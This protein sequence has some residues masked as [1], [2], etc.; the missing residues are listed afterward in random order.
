MPSLSFRCRLLRPVLPLTRSRALRRLYSAL[1]YLLFPVVVGRLLWRSLRLPAYRRRF[2]ERLGYAAR[3]DGAAPV[4]VHAVSVGEA[5]AAVP[6]VR[7]LRGR[8]P[9]IP[10]AMTTMTP[11]GAERVRQA[12]GETVKHSYVP[13]DM[14]G[15]VSR[16]LDRVR[17]RMVI[18]VETEL[19]PNLIHFAARRGVPV[20]LVNARLSARSAARYAWAGSLVRSM[21]RDL[22]ALACQAEPD[23]QRFAALGVDPK[24]TCVTGNVKFDLKLAASLREEAAVVRREW[25]VSRPVWVA[26]STHEGEE[27]QV[28]TAAARVKETFPDCLL[29]LVPRHPERFGR[30]A[31][32]CRRRGHQVVLRSE[33]RLCRAETDVFLGDSM[34]ELPLFYAASDVAFVGGSL[35]PVGGHNVVEPAALGMPVLF[36][37]HVFNF[38]SICA[39]LREAGVGTVVGDAAALAAEVTTYLGDA[40]LRHAAGERAR[41]LADANRGAL[42]AV[43]KVLTPFLD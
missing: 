31:S 25:G 4:W 28:L 29:V 23:A 36:G 37:P 13:Y 26:A 30:V 15:A 34:G 21:L 8:Y 11:T 32:L 35:V 18:L 38:E 14:P 43:L 2:R 5:Q 27:D 22:S 6:L 16:F 12:L 33:K 9:G 7:T 42:E 19:W 1:W 3:S 40:D 24:A 41:A 17:P 20:V 39:M 10:V